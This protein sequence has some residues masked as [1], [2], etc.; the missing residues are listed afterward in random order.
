MP[1][2]N[3]GIG[4][5]KF[6]DDAPQEMIIA[7]PGQIPVPQGRNHQCT[8]TVD[9]EIRHGVHQ[10]GFLHGESEQPVHGEFKNL[11]QRADAHGKHEGEQR[12]E[13]GREI[14]VDVLV[15]VEHVYQQET[16]DA[17]EQA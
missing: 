12:N 8:A 5:N 6:L 9:D 7:R 11:P 13:F 3:C 14:E 1:R 2:E 15:V 4:G 17:A 10:T 16:D